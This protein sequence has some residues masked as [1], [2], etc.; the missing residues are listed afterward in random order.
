MTDNAQ[1]RLDVVTLWLKQFE[2]DSSDP[3]WSSYVLDRFFEEVMSAPGSSIR[4][5]YQGLDAALKTYSVQLT[6]PV[7]AFIKD[8]VIRCFTRYRQSYESVNW[9]EMVASLGD[10]ATAAQ[11]YLALHSIPPQFVTPRLVDAIAKGLE[12]TAFRDEAVS[13]LAV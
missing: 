8:V 12:G 7:A 4:D 9:K 11:L 5:V 10:K 13:A 2:L 3:K 1:D 6:A